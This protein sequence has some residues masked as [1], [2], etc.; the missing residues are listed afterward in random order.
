MCLGTFGCCRAAPAL[1]RVR[2]GEQEDRAR[3]YLLSETEGTIIQIT[4]Y[5]IIDENHTQKNVTQFAINLPPL[6]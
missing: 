3:V 6:S 1:T 4:D 5:D 2:Y